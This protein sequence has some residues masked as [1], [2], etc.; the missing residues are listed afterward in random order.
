MDSYQ[1]L[2]LVVASIIA[3]LM[4]VDPNVAEYF[5]LIFKMVGLNIQ[6]YFWMMR[7]H[8]NNFVTTWIQNRKY[9]RL[10]RELEKEFAE[11]GQ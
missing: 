10:A 8:P 3:W 2:I 1:Y 4:I 9:D 11:K 6:R 7:Y 5:T